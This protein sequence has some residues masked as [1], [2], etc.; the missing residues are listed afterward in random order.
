MISAM[1]RVPIPKRAKQRPP[2][3][4]EDLYDS[5]AVTD[6]NI[7]ALWRHQSH[8]LGRYYN[9][10]ADAR[11]VALELPTGAGKTLVGLLIADWR[12]RARGETSAFICPTRQL[13]LQAHE[14]AK[15]YG[16]PTVLLIGANRDWDPAEQTR[17]LSGDATIVSVYSHIFNT[18]PKIH[19]DTLVLDDAHAGEGPVAKN[20][21]VSV[22]RSSPAYEPLLACVGSALSTSQLTEL[23]DDGLDPHARPVPQLVGP[24]QLGGLE[25]KVKGVLT[26]CL[27][28]DDA[29]HFALREIRGH[30]SGCLMYVAWHEILIRPFVPPTRFHGTFAEADQRVYLSATLGSAGELERAFGRT[31]IPRVETPS[32]WER[33]G[34]GRRLALLPRAGMRAGEAT[35]F[36]KET[37]GEF[38]RALVLAPSQWEVESVQVLLPDN[39]TLL[40]KKD[41]QETFHPFQES[42]KTALILANRYDGIDLPGEQCEAIL[43]SGLPTGTH[44]QERFLAETVKA[45]SAL[46]ERIR[47]RLMQGMG[48]ATR[49]RSDRAVILMAGEDLI[50]FLRDPTSLAG[51]RPELQAELGYGLFLAQE[52]GV[53]LSDIVESFLARDDDWEAAEAYLRER[54]DEANN[55][56]PEGAVQLQEAAPMEVRACEAAWRGE[57]DE[58]Y[59]HAQAAVRRLTVG[60]VSPYRT[61]WK[62]LAAHWAAQHANSTSDPVD[63]RIAS[64]LIRDAKAAARTLAW[65]PRLPDIKPPDE[66]K[67]LGTRAIQIASG[68]QKLAR[69]PKADRYVNEMVAWIASD[70]AK[71]FE[72]GLERLGE[73]LG[74]DA[75]RPNVSAAPDSAWRD[76]RVHFLWEAKSEQLNDGDLSA[77]M[78]RQ[79]NTH[80]TWVEREL[81]WNSG[82]T[83]VTLLASPRAGIDRNASATVSDH[84]H[85]VDM[86]AVRKLAAETASLWRTLMPRAAGLTLTELAD[87]AA[88]EVS[89]RGLD[90]ENLVSRLE[91]K[92][93]VDLPVAET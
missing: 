54:A 40:E 69:S 88:A 41:V 47:T 78:I 74:F 44:L 28:D 83:A 90:T 48:R 70:S 60:A 31:R 62:V 20:W 15:G 50:E 21:S 26:E 17:G 11:D 77:E 51:L 85:L 79:A 33:R 12:R 89:S 13:A 14:K 8:V 30:L 39:W 73:M 37:L 49:G 23:K 35:L 81:D 56:P 32:E 45:R 29:A 80:P 58:A 53:D 24:F 36:I 42:D 43:I 34:S 84:V 7:G 75:V 92:R 71:D 91:A 93:M 9:E 27:E 1:T 6:E 76:E 59:A 10:F 3:T 63:L 4:P 61:H 68:V 65:M 46:R 82:A 67:D 55:N 52:E 72:Q 86:G 87:Q 66:V 2:T 25:D 64:E 57:P 19:P 38:P 22:G 16:I 18:S 5:L